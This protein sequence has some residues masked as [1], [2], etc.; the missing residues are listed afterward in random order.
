MTLSSLMP[1][2]STNILLLITLVGDVLVSVSSKVGSQHS[3]VGALNN[4]LPTTDQYLPHDSHKPVPNL[5]RWREV[6]VP[7]L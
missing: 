1:S 4:Y 5:P 7:I 2:N 6:A 3:H